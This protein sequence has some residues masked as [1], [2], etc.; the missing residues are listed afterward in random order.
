MP[1]VPCTKRLAPDCLETVERVNTHVPAVCIRCKEYANKLYKAER[2]QSKLGNALS[3]L[4]LRFAVYV[5]HE[6]K[7]EMEFTE[8]LAKHLAAFGEHATRKLIRDLEKQL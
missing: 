2:G 8:T 6:G 5:P 4:L 1:I 3:H 7:T